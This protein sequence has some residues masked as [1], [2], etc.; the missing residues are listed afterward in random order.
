[1]G[2]RIGAADDEAVEGQARIE[3]RAAEIADFAA[4]LRDGR[5]ARESSI[6]PGML[7]IAMRSGPVRARGASLGR[8][9]AAGSRPSVLRTPM[10]DALHIA[11]LGAVN[12]RAPDR[13]SGIRSS[14]S[15]SGWEPSDRRSPRPPN[16]APGDRTSWRRCPRPVRP[17][18][19][20]SPAPRHPTPF[21]RR[22]FHAAL[23]GSGK[24]A[25]ILAAI[26][27]CP[28]TRSR[29]T[30][31]ETPTHDPLL[32]TQGTDASQVIQS[33]GAPNCTKDYLI[34]FK[35]RRSLDCRPL[36]F[37]QGLSSLPLGKGRAF[38]CF[39]RE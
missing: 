33:A 14:S 34:T 17:G 31:P 19:G 39:L 12:A 24:G 13:H 3:R 20:A 1:M 23:A 2:E 4:L 6:S 10:D 11:G 15:G 7:G 5:D 18:G 8:R 25:V 29:P 27:Q 22:S 26:H 21:V 36:I 37:T 38:A 35:W 30:R 16:P 32:N 9:W 28:S